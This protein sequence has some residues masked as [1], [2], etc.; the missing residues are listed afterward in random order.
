MDQ[1]A[2]RTLFAI[3]VVVFLLTGCASAPVATQDPGLAQ[4]KIE[5]SVA[6][7]VAA[8]DAQAKDQQLIQ[9]AVAL[10]VAAQNARATAQQAAIV[11]QTPPTQAAEPVDALPDIT[12]STAP[13][14]EPVGEPPG[15]T[16]LTTSDEGDLGEE[17]CNS[18]LQSILKV[19]E[20]EIKNLPSQLEVGQTATVKH[21]VNLR[22]QPSFRNRIILVLRPDAQVEI[23]DGPRETRFG[24]G[25]KYVWWKV[26]LPGGLTGWSAEISVCRQFYFMEPV[27]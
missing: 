2:K 19:K 22:T 27:K 6:L 15:S 9:Q 18:F 7:T 13:T 4:Q 24:N 11:T 17:Y 10:T 20:S 26:K 14:G 8:Q 21:H 3:M 23:I 12:D 1:S 16:D 25:T 5:Q